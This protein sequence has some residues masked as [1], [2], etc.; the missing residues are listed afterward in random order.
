MS[1]HAHKCII[2]ILVLVSLAA[3]GFELASHAASTAVTASRLWAEQ[4]TLLTD[5]GLNDV[6]SDP[7][8]AKP[9]GNAFMDLKQANGALASRTQT[10]F[11]QNVI[12]RVRKTT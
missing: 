3:D 12:N 10:K 8:T 11:E 1:T 4:S 9:F 5:L 2:L 6:A 7:T